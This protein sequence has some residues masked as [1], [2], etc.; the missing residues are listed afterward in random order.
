MA[1]ERNPFDPIP[2]IK[3][4]PIEIESENDEATIEYDDSDGG[5]IVEFKNPVEELLSDEQVEETD[6]EFYRNLADDID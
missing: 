6:D 2:Q 5:V 3:V 4:T 1:T